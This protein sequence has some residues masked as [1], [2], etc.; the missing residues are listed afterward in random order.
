MIRFSPPT[1]RRD[2]IIVTHREKQDLCA[3]AISY[4]FEP[5]QYL[6]MFSFTGV[7]VPF[8]APIETPDIFAIQRIRAE[9]FAVFLNNAILHN[10]GCENLILLGLTENQISYLNFLDRYNVIIIETMTDLDALLSGF[11]NKK[12]QI[13]ECS[14]EQTLDTLIVGLKTNRKLRIGF[15]GEV[16]EDIE[17]EKPNGIVIIEKGSKSDTIIALNYAISIGADAL[18]VDEVDDDAANEI[19]HLL[20]NL[21]DGNEDAYGKLENRIKTRIGEIDFQS[22]QFATFFTR[23]MPYSLTVTEIPVSYVHLDYKPDF[24]V[25]NAIF[26][27][28]GQ[29]T[30]SAVVFSP[31]FFKDEETKN[32]ISLLEFKNFYVRKLVGNAADV[33]NLKNT[34]ELYAFD[35]LHICSHGGDVGGTRCEVTF[36]DAEDVVHTIEF[37]HILT[38]ALTPYLDKHV[39]ESFYYFKKLD[40]LLWKSKELRALNYPHELYASLISEISM[41]FDQK[42][43]KTLQDTDRVMNANAIH[44]NVF[45]YLANFDQVGNVKSPPL[46]FNNACFSW[47][48]VSSSFLSAGARGYIGT[49][50]AVENNAAIR[51]AEVFYEYAFDENLID[52]LHAARVAVK[53]EARETNHIF[54]GL[55][56]STLNNQETVKTN[57]RKAV[58]HLAQTFVQ[59]QMKLKNNKGDQDLIKGRISDTQWLLKSIIL[60]SRTGLGP[61]GN[62]RK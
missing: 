40:G 46:I 62:F 47:M 18:F 28:T 14:T 25:H 16:L 30:G 57:E 42:S 45:N 4:L 11:A 19:L 2:F 36:R 10:G 50:M 49:L 31:T 7:D 23:G 22:F 21:N 61:F 55:H 54:W 13:I 26:Y 58:K 1:L 29:R 53:N 9:H 35:L 24:F 48:N 39:V 12:D 33:Y 51:Y 38:V 20:E 59:W 60:S 3:A 52:A 37:D 8:N 44:C 5:E 43:V 17:S 32:L 15:K 56:F 6:S 34:I 27:E 41:A